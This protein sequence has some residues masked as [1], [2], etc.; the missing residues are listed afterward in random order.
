MSDDNR[1][2]LSVNQLKALLQGF[3]STFWQGEGTDWFP[4]PGRPDPT[5]AFTEV[6]QIGKQITVTNPSGPGKTETLHGVRYYT[7]LKH[8]STGE[9][10][11]EEPGYF[12]FDTEKQTFIRSL[13]IPRGISIL[14]AG[15]FHGRQGET[16]V[17]LQM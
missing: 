8:T 15:T 1:I 10:L 12:L 9:A 3:E 6:M 5:V 7:Q 11:H 4:V 17:E 13:S 14:A 2:D 16:G